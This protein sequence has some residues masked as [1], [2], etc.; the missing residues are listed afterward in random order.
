MIT[1]IRKA[2]GTMAQEITKTNCSRSLAW[3]TAWKKV[4]HNQLITLAG[5]T[6]DN[7]QKTIATLHS[8]KREDI[9]ITLVRE[10][11]NEFDKNAIKVYAKIPNGKIFDIGYIP[12][13]IAKIYAKILDKEIKITYKFDS[14]IGGYESKNYGVIIKLGIA[15]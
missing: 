12:K 8:Y 14:V 1:N 10:P 7:R 3:I 13:E 9:K 4:K 6:F 5:T 15:A 2:V 11:N